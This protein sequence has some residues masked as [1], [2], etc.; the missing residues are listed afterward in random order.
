MKV[1]RV[2]T[3]ERVR[4]IRNSWAEAKGKAM[5]VYSWIRRSLSRS[6]RTSTPAGEKSKECHKDD[7]EEHNIYGVTEALIEFIKSFSVETFRNLSLPGKITCNTILVCVYLYCV[8]LSTFLQM[9]IELFLRR[10]K[11]LPAT[12]DRIYRIGNRTMRCLFCPESRFYFF[13]LFFLM[14]RKDYWSEF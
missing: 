11:E 8:K 6:K 4:F 2:V 14:L 7:G 10:V 13:T 12:L 9:K 1:G 3:Q 5:D